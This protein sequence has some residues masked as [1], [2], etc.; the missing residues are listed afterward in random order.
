MGTGMISGEPSP[1][2]QALDTNHDGQINIV[3]ARSNPNLTKVFQTLDNG[4]EQLN[5]MEFSAYQKSK[6]SGDTNY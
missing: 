5:K 4:D 2:F 1:E 3:E 6:G